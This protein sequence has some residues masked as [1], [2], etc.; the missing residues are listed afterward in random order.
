[1]KVYTCVVILCG[2]IVYFGKTL[3]NLKVMQFLF[4][5]RVAPEIYFSIGQYHFFRQDYD[6]AVE[7]FE[8][9]ASYLEASERADNDG[10]DLQAAYQLGVIY[11]DGLGVTPDP[12]SSTALN[13]I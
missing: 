4:L 5:A 12:V 7:Y 11:Y 8:Q 6:R 10:Y 9:A 1:M 13:V 2:C 3:Y